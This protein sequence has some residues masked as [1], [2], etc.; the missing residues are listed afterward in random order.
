MSKNNQF[1]SVVFKSPGDLA[2]APLPT[3]RLYFMC[4]YLH[5]PHMEMLSDMETWKI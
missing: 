3:Q 5:C 2:S 4:V 1:F